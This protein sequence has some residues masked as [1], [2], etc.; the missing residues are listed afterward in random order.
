[1]SGIAPRRLAVAGT[2][3]IA[4]LVLP[5]TG[6]AQNTP[7]PKVMPTPKAEPAPPLTANDVSEALLQAMGGR[8][9]WDRAR[10]LCFTFAAARAHCWDKYTGNHRLE[11]KNQQGQ[12]FV[13]LENIN[14]RQGSA[15]LNGQPVPQDQL[16]AY[17][18]GA[19]QAWANDTYWLLMPYK[20]QDPGV[21]LEY[22][23]S[24]EIDGVRYEKLHLTFGQNV[25][26]TPG[27]QYWAYINPRTGL[28]ERWSYILQNQ[29]PNSQPTQWLWQ[30][31][32][33]YG[34]IML[35]PNRV[36]VGGDGR[37][38]FTGI[39]VAGDVPDTVYT[40]PQ[41]LAV[42][43]QPAPPQGQQQPPQQQ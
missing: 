43:D 40:S 11:G 21:N 22:V 29:D 8:P 27:D 15:F 16:Q 1:M 6:A 5:L 23:G 39:E 13:V 33:K 41:P 35:A 4:S 3:L 32:Q 31:W 25:G 42:G 18:D 19:Y 14:T 36:Q 9:A 26:L 38:E 34:S 37:I 12:A 2:F 30:G 17:L 7:K 20:L 10:H 28:M 24:E